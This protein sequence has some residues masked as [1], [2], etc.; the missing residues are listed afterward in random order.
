[1]A[2]A[3]VHDFAMTANYAVIC[4]TP[5]YFN[6]GSLLMGTPTDYIFLDWVPTDGTRVHVVPLNGS[7]QVRISITQSCYFATRPCCSTCTVID[8][9]GRA[10][11]PPNATPGGPT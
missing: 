6:L 5:L 1:M 2:G 7:K 4:E 10:A 11:H 8:V 9:A 3:W